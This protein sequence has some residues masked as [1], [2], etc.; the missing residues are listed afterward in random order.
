MAVQVA[1][2]ICCAVVD[3]SMSINLFNPIIKKRLA[4]LSQCRLCCAMHCYFA[5][6]AYLRAVQCSPCHAACNHGMVT[7][8]LCLARHPFCQGSHQHHTLAMDVQAAL[9]HT[10]A[11]VQDLL[12]L[13]QLFYC[14][15][16]QL[17]RQREAFLKQLRGSCHDT[18][19]PLDRA[20]Q[21]VQ[22][23]KSLQQ[24]AAEEY[25]TVLQ[26]AGAYNC[27]VSSPVALPVCKTGPVNCSSAAGLAQSLP[28]VA[29]VY[30]ALGKI[31]STGF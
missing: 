11:Q 8:L 4:N 17:R 25:R 31:C 7:S 30:T 18:S 2:R 10:E 26:F 15:L 14:K 3:W 22:I 19:C 9:D 16:G 28:C 1:Y 29:T 24:N 6:V 5:C 12:Y 20:V 21:H 23:M 13:R 27:G